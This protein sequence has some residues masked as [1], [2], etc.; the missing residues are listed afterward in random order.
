MRDSD[1]KGATYGPGGW[2][3]VRR[4]QA[5]PEVKRAVQLAAREGKREDGP[6]PA[7]TDNLLERYIYSKGGSYKVNPSGSDVLWHKFAWRVLGEPVYIV[8][9][10]ARGQSTYSALVELCEQMEEVER[11]L[12]KPSPDR[13]NGRG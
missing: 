1:R 10:A 12:R 8:V 9:R 7:G 3:S 11:G 2:R 4:E 13:W 5:R 6:A